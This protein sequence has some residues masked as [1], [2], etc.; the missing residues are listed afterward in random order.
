MNIFDWHTEVMQ[1]ALLLYQRILKVYL[2]HNRL[3]ICHDLRGFNIFITL[4]LLLKSMY[5]ISKAAKTYALATT[6]I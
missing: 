3:L 5:T 6:G 1:D 4:S 2:L